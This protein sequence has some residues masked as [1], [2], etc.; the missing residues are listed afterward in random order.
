[1]V[2]TYF[3]INI[4]PKSGFFRGMFTHLSLYSGVA[5]GGDGMRKQ[6]GILVDLADEFMLGRS[7]LAWVPNSAPEAWSPISMR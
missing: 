3:A 2:V 5:G 6:V 4:T 7:A 1:M